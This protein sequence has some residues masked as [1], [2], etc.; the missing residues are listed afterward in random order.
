MSNNQI[1]FFRDEIH[2]HLVLPATALVKNVP[3]LEPQL[4]NC[5]WVR[6]GWGDRN[7]YG[8]PVQTNLSALRALLLPSPAVIAVLGIQ[9]IREQ[10][11]ETNRVYS[12]DCPEQVVEAVAKFIGSYFVIGPGGQLSLVRDKPDGELFFKA[13]GIYLI[14]NTCNNWTS[15]GLRIAGLRCQPLL[16]F[17]PGQVEQSVRRNGYLP[18]V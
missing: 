9:G 16:N 5:P 13:R 10:V 7:Y 14:S 11:S 8:A 6:I 1:Y 2:T 12:I 4:G 3:A 17:L 15:R 18:L